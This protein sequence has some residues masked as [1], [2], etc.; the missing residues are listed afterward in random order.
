MAKATAKAGAEP[1]ADDDDAWAVPPA[2]AGVVAPHR[3]TEARMPAPVTAPDGA[4]PWAMALPVNGRSGPPVA[5][6]AIGLSRSV[7][8]DERKDRSRCN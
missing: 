1:A 8:D 5:A 3:T 6:A 2:P 7:G 4:V